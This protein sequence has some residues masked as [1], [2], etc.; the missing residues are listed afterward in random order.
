MLRSHILGSRLGRGRPLT[1]V[2]RFRKFFVRRGQ[3][4]HPSATRGP[5]PSAVARQIADSIGEQLAMAGMGPAAQ[6]PS[7]TRQVVIG[8]LAATCEDFTAGDTGT[9]AVLLKSR[10]SRAVFGDAFDAKKI[11]EEFSASAA[12]PDGGFNVGVAAARADVER[13]SLALASIGLFLA[14]KEQQ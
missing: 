8:Y 3:G 6:W 2:K 4:V 14:L 9:Q 5:I 13:R 1:L 12:A 10:C 11:C 7:G